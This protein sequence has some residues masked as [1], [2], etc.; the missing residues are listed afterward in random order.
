M[1]SVCRWLPPTALD[2]ADTPRGHQAL[3]GAAPF[4]L[5]GRITPPARQKAS[6][7]VSVRARFHSISCPTSVVIIDLSPLGERRRTL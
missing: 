7:P 4:F 6:M 3:A 5:R 1:L 2:R